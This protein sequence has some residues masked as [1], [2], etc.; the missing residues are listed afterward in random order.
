M[1]K[2]IT[3]EVQEVINY[4]V[5]YEPEIKFKVCKQCGKK[6][7]VS[8]FHS[9]KNIC[10]LCEW[11]EKY[12]LHTINELS[13][14]ENIIILDNILNY[15]IDSMN[16]FEKLLHKPLKYILKNIQKLNIRNIKMIVKANCEVCGT[17][18]TYKISEYLNR[19]NYFC[20]NECLAISQSYSYGCK[21]GYQRC[22]K[23][24]KEKPLSEFNKT[25]KN[26]RRTICNVCSVKSKRTL[27]YNNIFTEDVVN[28]IFDSLLNEKISSLNE[29][30]SLIDIELDLLI[31][32][33]KS[34]NIGAKPIKLE[35][36]CPV[37]ETTVYRIISQ[38]EDT[39]NHYCSK[40][41]YD[42]DQSME[43]LMSCKWCG[44]EF[45]KTPRKGQENYFC[46][47]DCC[48]K[49]LAIQRI[50]PLIKMICENCGKPYYVEEAQS[51]RRRFCSN[52]CVGEYFSG[53]NSPLYKER[54]LINCDW[55]GHPFEE[56]ES[57]YNLSKNHFCSKE[58]SQEYHVKVFSQTDEWK[59]F[60]RKEMV[61]RLSE[62]VFSHTNT[63]PQ[64]IINNLLDSMDI[65]YENEY[66][67]KHYSIDNYLIDYNLM[68]EIMGT[69]WHCD[70]RKYDT[71]N[72]L[73]Q[74]KTIRNDK[75]KKTYICNNHNINILYLWEY[76]INSN[77][78][79]CK[80][81]ILKYINNKGVL[82]NYHSFN[83]KI[84]NNN[85]Y[86]LDQ[87]IKPY[88]DFSSIKL[89]ALINLTVKEKM[90]KKQPDKWITYIC[91]YCGQEKEMLLIR[92]NRSKN[93][94]CST[95]CKNNF[96]KVPTIKVNCNNCNEEID[97]IPSKYKSN[98]NK[99]FYCN[100]RCY[101]EY[102]H[103][104][105]IKCFCL[106]C[107]KPLSVSSNKINNQHFCNRECYNKYKSNNKFIDESKY[108][109]FNCDECGKEKSQLTARYNKHKHHFCGKE[110]YD[111][112]QRN[113]NKKK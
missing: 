4:V 49:Y 25:G 110:C 47:N 14:D 38:M 17:E 102:L 10:K 40:E 23:C 83:Y 43:I 100:D 69:F 71:I 95:D 19:N 52:K 34:L 55:C 77:L 31:P 84:N 87:L 91:D 1:S 101:E 57:D 16:E 82:D 18:N 64:L 60:M 39:E 53:E 45:Y 66:N 3:K 5:K 96:Q 29:L 78:E 104:N 50:K 79:L 81:L 107:G 9:K 76:D 89:N 13:F 68:I 113:R 15:R 65:K 2:E 51:K 109:I 80:K 86:F 94:F 21:E 35:F 27:I 56:L 111:K 74:V 8:E 6:K 30:S 41:C 106:Y 103:S 108:T 93:H 20:S 98:K 72:Y 67:C 36:V 32:F 33:I 7:P 46:S 48:T 22:G 59:E 97:L 61:N 99:I 12:D 88:M 75:S 44:K 112:F 54:L 11:V 70:S 26:K 105:Q 62:G 37:C 92:Y 58:C 42:K 73:N 28:I 24:N 63:T 90:S 85:L